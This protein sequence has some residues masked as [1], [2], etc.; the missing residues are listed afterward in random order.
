MKNIGNDE[1]VIK[2][3]KIYF[4]NSYYYDV[5]KKLINRVYNKLKEDDLFFYKV[6]SPKINDKFKTYYSLN[7]YINKETLYNTIVEIG[8]RDDY[9]IISS[10]LMNGGIQKVFEYIPV[11]KSK[12]FLIQ[13]FDGDEISKITFMLSY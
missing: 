3:G 12:G 7:L 1:R 9:K 2:D 5:N 13:T 6:Q 8:S 11:D 10:K 4:G